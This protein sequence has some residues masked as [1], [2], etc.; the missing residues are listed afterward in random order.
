MFFKSKQQDRLTFLLELLNDNFE[1]GNDGNLGE[2]REFLNQHIMLAQTEGKWR[3]NFFKYFM[4]FCPSSR[5][6]NI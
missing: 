2:F 5:R 1:I 6:M 3:L 4:L